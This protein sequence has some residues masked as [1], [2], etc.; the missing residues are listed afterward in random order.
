MKWR[1]P[2]LTFIGFLVVGFLFDFGA[3]QFVQLTLIYVFVNIILALGLNLVN[4]FTGQFSLGHA[5]FMAVGAY[6]SA[7]I[8]TLVQPFGMG[9]WSSLNFLIFALFG[10]LFAA[11]AGWVVGLPSLRLKGDYLAI[12][13]LGFGE[14]IRVM[15]LN[16]PAIGGA[17]GMYGIPGPVNLELGGFPVSKFIQGYTVASFW[18]V[19]TFFVM[20]RLVR[21]SHGRA[22]MSVREDE[23]AAEAMGIN[24]TRTKVQAFV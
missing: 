11:A 13:T 18:L 4:G 1:N 3:N 6:T 21:S 5:G 9:I 15:L 17:R 19:L 14:I 7:Y 2:L 24:T 8:S 23:V 10:G 20:W 12:V 16:T 22:F